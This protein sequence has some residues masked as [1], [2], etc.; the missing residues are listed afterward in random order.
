M[1]WFTRFTNTFE[2]F[3]L[4]VL[5]GIIHQCCTYSQLGHEEKLSEILILKEYFAALWAEQRSVV[6]SLPWETRPTL[7]I[8]LLISWCQNSGS[9]KSLTVFVPSAY[10]VTSSR[11]LLWRAGNAAIVLIF[12]AIPTCLQQYKVIRKQACAVQWLVGKG[13]VIS[14][15]MR[16]QVL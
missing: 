9:K 14:G 13:N 1:S 12:G 10:L 7:C 4:T 11:K 6:E 15:M 2:I 3:K 16:Y 8:I 5:T